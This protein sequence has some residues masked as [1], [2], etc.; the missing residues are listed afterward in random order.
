MVV[1]A[2]AAHFIPEAI[3]ACRLYDRDWHP[4]LPRTAL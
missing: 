1:G 2:A 4:E 3:V